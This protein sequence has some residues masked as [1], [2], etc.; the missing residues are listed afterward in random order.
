MRD[1][2]HA[3]A[4]REQFLTSIEHGGFGITQIATRIFELRKLE[5]VIDSFRA[6][7]SDAFVSYRLVSAPADIEERLDRREGYSSPKQ[8]TG[9]WYK[10][11][12]GRERP[13]ADTS[14]L[15]LFA[16]LQVP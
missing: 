1:A 9:G 16:G 11:S 15:P 12:T 8:S 6:N 5:C 3:V 2:G 14:D 4:N 10:D 7:P 13:S